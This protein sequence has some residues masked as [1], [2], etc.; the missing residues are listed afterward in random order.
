MLFGKT[1]LPTIPTLCTM[2][3]FSLAFPRLSE[4]ILC[5][6]TS[7]TFSLFFVFGSYHGTTKTAVIIEAVSAQKDMLDIVLMIYF[8]GVVTKMEKRRYNLC[9]GKYLVVFLYLRKLRFLNY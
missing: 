6:S 4:T 8:A 9:C 3:S 2:Q 7:F 1:V 5:Y